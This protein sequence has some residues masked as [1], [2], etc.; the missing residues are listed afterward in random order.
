MHRDA[1]LT[2]IE[3]LVAMVILAILLGFG[4]PAFRTSLERQRVATALFL[5]SAQFASARSTAVTLRQPVGLCPSA[6]N[7][8]AGESDWNREWLMYR[9]R[10]GKPEAD[11]DSRILRRLP[12]PGHGSL[13][14]YASAGRR[15]LQF[16]H[17]GRSAG[18]N[19][20]LRVCAKGR[21]QGEVVVNNMG[22]IRS[23]RLPGTQACVP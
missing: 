14:L 4:L 2:A 21:A 3:L 12:P 13:R 1:G 10:Q 23:R 9:G 22:R 19:L 11:D 18:S 15:G 6:G 16:Q 8:C 20:R 17:D 7:A 5:V